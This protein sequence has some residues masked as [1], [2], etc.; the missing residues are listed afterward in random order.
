MAKLNVSQKTNDQTEKQ[1]QK[2]KQKN[3][4]FYHVGLTSLMSRAPE[5][6]SKACRSQGKIGKE[7]KLELDRKE[8]HMLLNTF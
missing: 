7:Y 4:I 1:L 5:S 3:C 2:K 6:Q 8:I